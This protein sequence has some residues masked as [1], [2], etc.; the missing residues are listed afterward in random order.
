MGFD[1]DNIMA[2]RKGGASSPREESKKLADQDQDEF[3]A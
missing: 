1:E 3:N 2:A